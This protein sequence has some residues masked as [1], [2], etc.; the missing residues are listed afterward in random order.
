TFH[1]YE[2]SLPM[3]ASTYSL[4]LRP[5]L[6]ELVEALG[7]ED[8]DV[9]ELQS[10]LTALSYLPPRTE[11]DAER[12]TERNREKEVIKDRLARLEEK[13]PEVTRAIEHVVRLFNGQVGE[14][15]SFDRLDALLDA[16]GFR[17]AYWRVAAEDINYR[18]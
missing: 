8:E 13:A 2:R 18:R 11:T 6:E 3:D 15:Q 12:L 16:Q 10:I 17:P 9:R 1:Y 14:P 4:V 7:E 5:V